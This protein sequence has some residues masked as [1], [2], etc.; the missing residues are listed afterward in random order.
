MIDNQLEF[1]WKKF[2]PKNLNAG[3]WPKISHRRTLTFELDRN[4]DEF[5]QKYI[6]KITSL[7]Q[8]TLTCE[9]DQKYP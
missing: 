4:M 9:Y 1:D 7:R 5:D 2:T 8:R 6:N 3:T